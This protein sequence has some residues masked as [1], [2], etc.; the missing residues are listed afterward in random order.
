MTKR[1]LI[2][3]LEACEAPDGAVV[4]MC[5]DRAYLERV[6]HGV[7]HGDKRAFDNKG[8]VVPTVVIS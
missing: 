2:A 3:A 4:L 8:L 1:E 7:A 5:S 6:V